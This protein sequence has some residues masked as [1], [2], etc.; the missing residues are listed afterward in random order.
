MKII[1]QK[2]NILR[3]TIQLRTMWRITL[4]ICWAT[5]YKM[6][7]GKMTIFGSEKVWKNESCVRRVRAWCIY[8]SNVDLVLLAEVKM[9]SVFRIFEKLQ[10]Q[11][12]AM[13]LPGLNLTDSQQMWLTMTL[14]WCGGTTFS[15]ESQLY[16]ISTERWKYLWHASPAF[17]I[18]GPFANSEKFSSP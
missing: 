10:K 8:W 18:L 14:Y 13:R 12:S 15:E 3:V 16:Q 17:C 7:Q 6:N 2:W 11:S 4:D 9:C 1:Q 5:G